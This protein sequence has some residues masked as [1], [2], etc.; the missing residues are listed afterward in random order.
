M[1]TSS[2]SDLASLL[3]NGSSRDR[4]EWLFR[5]LYGAPADQ[6]LEVARFALSRYLPIFRAKH[7]EIAWPGELLADVGAWVAKHETGLVDDPDHDSADT[8]FRHGLHALLVA[9]MRRDDDAQ[10]TAAAAVAIRAARSAFQTN[11]WAADDPE[12]FTAWATGDLANARRTLEDNAAA[13]AVGEREWLAVV[14]RL[15]SPA[16]S[17]GPLDAALERWRA[18]EHALL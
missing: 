6:A 11:V 16:A 15:A 4:A 7:R 14:G 8:S 13:V 10:R 2:A 5:A 9:W 3:A 18:R 1:T 17:S 12:A